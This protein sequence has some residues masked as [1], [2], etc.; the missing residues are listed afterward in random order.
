MD[1]KLI[2]VGGDAVAAEYE[3]TLPAVIGRSRSASIKV[4]QALVSRRH[5]ELYEQEGRLVVRDLGSLNGTFIG[6]DRI[7]EDTVL[8]PGGLLTIGSITF[9]AEYVGPDETDDN[10]VDTGQTVEIAR[11]AS[12]AAGVS[13]GDAAGA[14]FDEPAPQFDEPGVEAG[15]GEFPWLHEDAQAARPADEDLN[16]QELELELPGDDVAAQAEP[17][18]AEQLEF[19]APGGDLETVP[20]E[21]VKQDDEARRD[22]APPEK[23]DAGDGDDDLDDFFRSL[24][25]KK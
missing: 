12:K 13:A 22:F 5:C 6:S 7:A 20:L 3:L 10:T 18:H 17:S 2:V 1:A 21:T 19:A 14:A 8:P 9:K 24:D 15:A 25:I 16:L 23:A 4:P 11:G